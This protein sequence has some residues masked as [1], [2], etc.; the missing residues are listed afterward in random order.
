MN[1]KLFSALAAG[2]VL[3]TGLVLGGTLYA[4][5]RDEAPMSGM[6]GMMGM[7]KDCPMHAAMAERPAKVLEHRDELSLSGEQIARLEALNARAMAAHGPAMERMAALH[8]EIAAATSDENFDEGAVRA[9]LDRM[10]D[11]HTEMALAMMRTRHD[12]RSV[13]T[14]EQREK[15]AELGGGMMGM[16]EMMGMMGGMDMEDCPMMRGMMGGNGN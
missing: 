14:A 5:Q 2:V 13:L 9:A 11:L 7:M 3:T 15:L 12:V 1:R 4:Q 10:G 8:T 6:M 16:H